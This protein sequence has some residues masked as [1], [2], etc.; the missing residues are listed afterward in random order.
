MS[1]RIFRIKNIRKLYFGIFF[2]LVFST[3]LL[4]EVLAQFER[5][6][7]LYYI[8]EEDDKSWDKVH[9]NY[10]QINKAIYTDSTICYI[11]NKS[12]EK[13]TF[14]KYY[15]GGILH[16]KGEDLEIDK[17]GIVLGRSGLW[18]FYTKEGRLKKEIYYGDAGGIQYWKKYDEHG[19]IIKNYDDLRYSYG[20][21]VGT[22]AYRFRHSVR[23]AFA[24][25]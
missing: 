9:K 23:T 20:F 21:V 3:S 18:K 4:P 12:I 17:N 19:N 8:S 25:I 15:H 14:T 11:I 1:D 5:D 2:V 16:I 10:L 13:A 6:V 24:T 22:G 7:S